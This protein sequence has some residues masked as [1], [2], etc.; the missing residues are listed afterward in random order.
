MG[1]YY[2]KMPTFINGAGMAGGLKAG[3]TL[4][5]TRRV[6]VTKGPAHDP[7][8][9]NSIVLYTPKKFTIVEELNNLKSLKP[10]IQEGRIRFLTMKLIL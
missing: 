9:D 3:S 10:V 4:G 1:F 6:N 8:A 2:C 7:E 5:V